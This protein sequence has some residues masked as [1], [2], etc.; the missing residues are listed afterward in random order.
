[1]LPPDID[2]V[3]FD[4]GGT[5][6]TLDYPFIADLA[7]RRGARLL[8][9]ALP[10][11]DGRARL[12]MDRLM[13]ADRRGE[14]RDEGR[15]SA[16]FITLLREAGVAQALLEELAGAL[17][18]A[19]REDNLWRLP[20]PGVHQ[21]LDGLRRRGLRTGVVSNADGRIEA[22]LGALGLAEH[23]DV[24]VD[25]YQEGVEKPDPEIFRR[26]VERLGSPP[27]RTA[28]VGDIYSIDVVGARGAGLLPVVL[29]PAGAYGELDCLKIEALEELL[30]PRGEA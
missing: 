23:L 19:H 18:Q 22:I 3:L 11:A 25:S 21:A 12:A 13:E 10:Q 17:E 5:L 9:S 7:Q 15:R 6:V 8:V 2:A 14:S 4:A 27:E 20:Q 29:D 30:G 24:M 1:V 16:Y 28:Y 26:A